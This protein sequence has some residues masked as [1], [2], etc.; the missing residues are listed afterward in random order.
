VAELLI[1][2][3]SSS[4]FRA[5]HALPELQTASGVPSHA[6]LG[7]TNMLQ[8]TLRERKPRYVAIA[9][10]SSGPRRR[11]AL[12]AEYK[13][14]RDATPETLRAQIPYV[15]RVVSAYRLASFEQPG[16]EADDVIATLVRLGV[17]QGLDVAIVS[18][19]KDLMQLVG[20]HVRLLDTMR[21]REY[22][23]DEVRER[24][25]VGPDQMLDF[26]ALTGDPSD[27]IPGVRGI[28]EKGAAQLL[29]QFGTLDA[30]LERVDEISATRSRNALAQGADAA[31]L[32]RDLARL[33][34]DLPLELDLDAL[35]LGD[36][37]REALAELFQELEFRRLLD[38]LGDVPG[39]TEPPP[40]AAL[41]EV[42]SVASREALDALAA[43]LVSA[44]CVGVAC[45]LEP[46][47]GMRGDWVGLGLATEP[48]RAH[49]A[50]IA[51]LGAE[52][53]L[54]TLAPVFEAP[55]ITWRG[56]SLK[57]LSLALSRAGIA[58][59]GVLAEPAVAAYL[60]DASQQI[61]RIEVLAE[62]YLGRRVPA[63]D[64]VL[65]KGAKR[66]AASELPASDLADFL[67][68]RAALALELVPAIAGR[69]ESE[70]QRALWSEL[71]Q[72]L[73]HVLARMEGV[74]VRVDE[75]ALGALSRELARDLERLEAEIHREAGEPF[76]IAS[77]KQLQHVLFEKLKLPPSKKTKTGFS[78]DESVLEELSLRYPLPRLVLDY[79]RLA[80][81]KSTY[82]DALPRLVH[83]ETGRIH[84][85]FNQTVAATGRLSSS[86]PNLQNIPIRTPQ[87]Q[88]IRETFIPA[89]GF[90]LLSADY[91]QIELRILAHLSEDPSLI[92]TFQQG[93]DVH[94][95]TAA[96]VFGIARE[97]VTPD[98]RDRMKAVNFGILYGSSAFGLARQLGIA[99]SAAA[100]H[101]RAYFERYPR[102]RS[103]LDATIERARER[104]YAETLDGRRRYLPD[105]SSRNRVRRAAAERMATNSVIQGTAADLIKRAMVELDRDLHGAQGLPAELILQVHDELVFEARPE[106]LAQLRQKV[107]EAMENVAELRVPLMVH[108]GEGATWLAAH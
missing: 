49:V 25:G 5:F 81:L 68:G 79:R 20:P 80:K 2:D 43:R 37:D 33:R 85:Q 16:E 23:P 18:T 13:A 48:G 95:D 91:S 99:Q 40:A 45:A 106:C 15:R 3:A 77:T 74:G 47:D 50:S 38:E 1:V 6:T 21:N 14:K 60:V 26:R 100:E 105:L 87:G 78:T 30:A 12:F 36:P 82:V 71:E 70:G 75:D 7:F 9:W 54:E 53:V 76:N 96:R 63:D 28:G 34:E 62:A 29:E 35:R 44:D 51:A 73:T 93:G 108:L 17:A 24:F 65:G 42:V 32:S 58:L 67:G 10:D 90:V 46:A 11:D 66:R 22:G 4:L 39:R 8:K 72:P 88:R 92:E 94:V 61:D 55:S 101:I 64:D 57:A 102:V 19:D 103:F 83:P 59:R 52:A 56:P 31:H 107:A 104:G 27:N 69:L 86:N 84:C 41:V 98:Q 89:E 97:A